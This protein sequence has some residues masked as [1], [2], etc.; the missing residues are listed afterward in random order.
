MSDGYG[1]RRS[2]TVDRSPALVGLSLVPVLAAAVALLVGGA[3]VFRRL[4]VESTVAGVPLDAVFGGLLLVSGTCVLA[5]GIASYLGL[6]KTTP[7]DSPGVA[8]A[9]GFGAVAVCAV[10]LVGSLTFGLEGLGW[11][12]PALVAGLV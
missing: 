2:L 8:V 7:A 3:A 12:L 10:G 4:P 9:A 5:L 6:G 11:A 1:S